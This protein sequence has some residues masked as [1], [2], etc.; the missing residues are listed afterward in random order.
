[1]SDG[2][3]AAAAILFASW[4]VAIAVRLHEISRLL[5]DIKRQIAYSEE[6]RQR[7]RFP[8]T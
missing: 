3:I 8:P 2:L 4:C 7:E 6:Q 1:M 5:T